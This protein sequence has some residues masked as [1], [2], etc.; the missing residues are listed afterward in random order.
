MKFSNTFRYFGIP[1]L[2]WFI[3]CRRYFMK[4]NCPSVRPSVRPRHNSSTNAA[5]GPKFC[6]RHPNFRTDFK[7]EYGPYRA[8]P[9][10]LAR[11]CLG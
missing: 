4:M 5:R 8:Y 9:E 2:Q 10:G 6:M 11:R 7:F 1:V 3:K